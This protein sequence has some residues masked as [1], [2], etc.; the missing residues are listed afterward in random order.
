[1]ANYPYVLNKYYITPA[2]LFDNKEQTEHIFL[3]W[4][5]EE[6]LETTIVEE[7]KKEK[8]RFGKIASN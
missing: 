7:P 2:W 3:K 6:N 5:Q 4:Q 8:E 1:L